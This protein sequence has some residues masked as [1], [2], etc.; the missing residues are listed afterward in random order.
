MHQIVYHKSVMLKVDNE[1]MNRFKLPSE[2]TLWRWVI[3]NKGRLFKTYTG[4][5]FSYDLKKG[6]NGSYTKELWIDRRKGSKSLAW[7]SIRRAYDKVVELTIENGGKPVV[8]RPKALGDIRGISYIY[9]IFYQ[10]GI[11]EVP[12]SIKIKMC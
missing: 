1:I 4:L 5:P 12:E 8:E 6:R 3:E 10:F 11:I 2:E 9:G 7:G